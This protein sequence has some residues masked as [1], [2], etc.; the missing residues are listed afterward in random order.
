[1][2]FNIVFL[3]M[4]VLI[5]IGL[6]VY[7]GLKAPDTKFGIAFKTSFMVLST[8]ILV[9]VFIKKFLITKFETK[10]LAKQVALEHDYSIDNGNPDKIKYLWYNNERLL[11][12]FNLVNVVLYGGFV[13]VISVGISSALMKV[14]FITM[15]IMI[16]YTLAYTLKFLILI[17]RR[18]IHNGE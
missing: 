7:E 14:R 15:V 16:L 5:P 13:A 18:D 9:W 1:M 11:A 8:S 6:I 17:S 12:I 3:I 10:L 2:W 4:T